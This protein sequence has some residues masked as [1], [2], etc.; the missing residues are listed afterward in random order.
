MPE[1]VQLVSFDPK[2]CLILHSRIF[3]PL[4][5]FFLTPVGNAVWWGGVEML[6][7]NIQQTSTEMHCPST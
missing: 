5:A 6:Y 4:L 1:P 7:R 3:S 2:Y